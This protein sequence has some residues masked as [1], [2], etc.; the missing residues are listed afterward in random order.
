MQPGLGHR[1]VEILVGIALQCP[2]EHPIKC[3]GHKLIAGT[4]YNAGR[5]AWSQWT[6]LA[7]ADGNRL[8]MDYVHSGK[9]PKPAEHRAV[10]LLVHT[11]RVSKLGAIPESFR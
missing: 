3:A 9:E 6:P 11:A 2:C 10:A 4:D 8:P 7:V 5:N 1:H